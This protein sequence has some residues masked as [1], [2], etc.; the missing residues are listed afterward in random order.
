LNLDHVGYFDPSQPIENGSGNLPHWRQDGVTYFVT[1][2]LADAIPTRT[3][4]LWRRERID[5][6]ERNPPPHS[7]RQLVDYHERFVSRYHRWLDAGVG[8]CVLADPGVRQIVCAAMV[9]FADVRYALRE[10][11]VMPNHV[12][13]VISPFAGRELSAIL[14]SW[15]SFTANEINRRLRRHG[16]LWQKESFGHIVRSPEQL[17]RIERYIHDNPSGFSADKCTLGCIHTWSAA[18]LTQ[19]AGSR[20]HGTSGF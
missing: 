9:H 8:A 18:L 15:K 5:W 4:D 11:V 13:V 14:H 19:A 12:H 1:F 2:R 7:K 17:E 10:W 16:S 20:F 3:L 6:L